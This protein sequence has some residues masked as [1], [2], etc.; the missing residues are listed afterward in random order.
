[1]KATPAAVSSSDLGKI[2]FEILES[3][4]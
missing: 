4:F 3:V 2:L 1:M